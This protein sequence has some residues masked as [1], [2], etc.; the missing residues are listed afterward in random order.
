MY[1][2]AIHH[3]PKSNTWLGL[4]YADKINE[5]STMLYYVTAMYWSITTLSTT[6]Y[7][8]LHATNAWEMVFT[9]IFMVFN[10]GLSS[11]IIGNMT[12]LVVHGT[13][14]TRKFVS[15]FPLIFNYLLST[16]THSVL[17]FFCISLLNATRLIKLKICLQPVCRQS[18]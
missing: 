4:L 3:K 17:I 14:R 9:T 2:L 11:Y 12:N 16:G 10:L 1:L 5:T 8:D 6:G 7:G 18:A 13:S 15:D